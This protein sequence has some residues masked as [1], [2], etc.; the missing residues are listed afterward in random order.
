MVADFKLAGLRDIPWGRRNVLVEAF[1]KIPRFT[2]AIE[3]EMLWNLVHRSRIIRPSDELYFDLESRSKYP[4]HSV[5]KPAA[6][7]VK[8]S[9]TTKEATAMGS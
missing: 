7:I 2:N 6:L 4:Y 3:L 1:S 9:H 5:I 8:Y